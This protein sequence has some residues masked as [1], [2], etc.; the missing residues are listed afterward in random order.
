[1]SNYYPNPFYNPY[2]V[3]NFNGTNMYGTN[4]Q[5]QPSVQQNAPQKVSN[6]IYVSGIEG[7]R[8]YNL[9]P[10][11]EMLLCDD[12]KNIVYDV[13]VDNQGKRTITALDVREHQEEPPV[14]FSNFATKD[15]IA[16]L[17]EELCKKTTSIQSQNRSL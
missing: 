13:I 11:S 7:A 15:D 12:T 3:P 17:R 8:S 2:N 9:A 1:M 14:D 4:Y 6:K 16:K 5:N 10:N